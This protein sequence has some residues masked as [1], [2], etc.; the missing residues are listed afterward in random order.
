MIDRAGC[1]GRLVHLA[2]DLESSF[3]GHANM[4]KRLRRHAFGFFGQAKQQML[5]AH[6][7]LV[8]RTRLLLGKHEHMARFIGKFFECHKRPRFSNVLRSSNRPQRTTPNAL[9]V[10]LGETLT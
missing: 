2:N 8:Q 6:M 1:L 10:Q 4:L 3:V 9:A 7:G 5:A